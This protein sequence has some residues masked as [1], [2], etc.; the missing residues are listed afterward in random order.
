MLDVAPLPLPTRRPQAKPGRVAGAGG[1]P[2]PTDRL[3]A[4]VALIAANAIW[5]TTF[6]ATRPLL[7]R[8]PP[9]TLAAARVAV[10]L[11]V[12]LPILAL[13]GRR[14]ARGRGPALLGFTGVFLL[15]L[16]QNV[17]LQ[18]TGAA[19]GALIHG[20]LPVLTA[21]LAVPLLG[22]RLDGHRVG[23]LAASLLGVAAVVLWGGRGLDRAI[24]GDALLLGS[25]VALAF[26]LVLGRRSF[27][28][29]NS[30]ELVA[31]A[32]CY[33]VLFLLP[34]S[35][36]ELALTGPP[37]PTAG[38]LLG[39]LYLGGVASALAFLLCGHGLRHLEA[40]QVGLFANLKTVVGAAVAAT[41]LG[42]PFAAP[43]VT[44]ALLI[45][46]GVWLAARRPA[47]AIAAG[48]QRMGTT[49]RSPG[50]WFVLPGA[51][52]AG[53]DDLT[54]RRPQFNPA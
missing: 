24:L 13:A 6:V 5:G 44:G 12:L 10:A 11:L 2:W 49:P 17:G 14:P 19:N 26:Y 4:V 39:L 25:A 42:E 7:E 9:I 32:A 31:G 37:R 53:D 36:L 43:Q 40:A 30:L 48:R 51:A 8:V 47:P 38:D 33:G 29:C 34:A 41:I 46:G 52:V 3:A 22:E 27:P 23:G 1:L 28:G 54:V 16:C 18:F 50:R 45:L 15:Y 20:G 35:A 21:L